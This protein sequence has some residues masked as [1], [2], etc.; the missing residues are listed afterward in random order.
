M[1]V[2]EMVRVLDGGLATTLSAAGHDLDH[3]LWSARVLLEDPDAVRAAHTAFVRAGARCLSTVTYQAT[4][5]GLEAQGIS[6][7]RAER[8]LCKA[9]E[10][11]HEARGDRSAE[12]IW[13]AASI[14]PYGAFL[15]DGSEYR[16]DYG[17]SVGELRDFHQERFVLLA[18]TAADVLA[19]ETIP[20]AA[21]AMALLDL[22]AQ[23]EHVRAWM[24]FTLA[25]GK[26]SGNDIT[27]E[28]MPDLHEHRAWYCFSIPEQDV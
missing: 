18:S 6:H 2:G 20:D 13:V 28:V 3:P 5:Q 25:R 15:A 19:L 10:L 24:S 27:N 14:G 16:G 12:S 23:H 7:R 22:L 8:I 17:L 1:A 9:V 4:F 21:E 11:A 26:G